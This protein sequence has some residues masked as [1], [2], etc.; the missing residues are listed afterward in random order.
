MAQTAQ[1]DEKTFLTDVQTLRARAKEHL[2]QGPVTQNY[3]G[4]ARKAIALLQTVVATEIVC[5]LR[6]TMNS[7]AATGINSESV[8][9]EFAEHAED[10][11]QHM[12]MAAERIDQLGGTPNLDP[13]GLATRSATEYGN[14]GNLVQMITDN[15]VAERVVIEHYRELIRYFGENDPTTRVMLE[16]ILGDE[17]DHAIDMHDLLVAH[18]GT[19]MLPGN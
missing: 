9:A 19:P 6:Y 17:E 14:G 15:L 1:G 13:E 8:A 7:I 5:V 2:D 10:E 11:R 18:E 3:G 4:D 16:K 12:K